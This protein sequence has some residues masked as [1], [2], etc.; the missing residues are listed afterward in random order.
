MSAFCARNS[1]LASDWSDVRIA[2][3]DVVGDW[4]T[5]DDS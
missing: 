1:G 2:R 5:S 4:S 3:A